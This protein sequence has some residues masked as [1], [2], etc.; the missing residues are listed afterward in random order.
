MSQN[1]GYANQNDI[2]GEP[3]VARPTKNV[4]PL[5]G[6]VPNSQVPN[7][8]DSEQQI[9]R[10]KKFLK[11]AQ[12][13]VI[14]A[15][16]LMSVVSYN[17][18]DSINN[19]QGISGQD[20]SEVLVRTEGRQ[21]DEICQE[22]GSDILI[23]N[24][25]N[26]NG[27]LDEDEVTS[28]TR[29]CHGKEGL[30]GPQGA[31]GQSG[32]TGLMSLLNTE[33]IPFGNANCP[34]GGLR[35]AT[36][37]DSD[38]N[39]T[40]EDH[41][42]VSIDYVCNGQIGNNGISGVSG[43]SALVEQHQPPALLCSNG[44][45]IE[46]GVDDG[47]GLGTADDGILHDDEIVE[48]LRICAEPL[49]YGPITDSFAGVS[50]GYNNACSEFAYLPNSQ[51]I[52]TSGADGIH[53]CELWVSG[54]TL[55]TSELLL[56]IN[57]GNQDSVPGQYL[58]FN[59]MSNHNGELVAFDA[60][61]GI[62]GRELWIT[63]IQENTTTQLTGY[64]GDGIN[65]DASSILW[66]GGM[67]F[68]DS[69]YKFMWTDG[70]NVSSLFDAPFITPEN[71]LLLSS[72]ANSIAAHAQTT[73]VLDEEGMW[74]SA[75]K[76]GIGVEMHRLSNSGIL[77]SWD[78]NQFEDSMPHSIL[79]LDDF[80]VLVADDGLNGKQIHRVN[81]SGT[82]QILTSLTVSSTGLPVSNLANGIG[83]N[84]I[85]DSL[86][87]DAQTS[88]V[89]STV[90]SYNLTS[91]QS[92]ELSQIVLAPGERSGA[93]RIGD[94]LWFDCV[95][96]TTAGELCFSDGTPEGTKLVYEFQP[97][98]ASS[99]IRS[100]ESVDNH[101]LL[102]L[103]GENGGVDSGHCLWSFDTVNMVAKIAYDPW[104]GIGNNSQSG[105]YGDL[106]ISEDV[107]LFIANDGTSGHE[108]HFWSPQ[109]LGD[110]WLIW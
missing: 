68:T 107:A 5:S 46:F 51:M 11:Y 81:V 72:V 86:I 80:A 47:S 6:R 91:G 34:Y 62:N 29:I 97:G 95:T 2:T 20:A 79:P 53:G 41:E 75:V 55:S 50:D 83:I 85:G 24:D 36:G 106:L 52:I 56:D 28:L 9:S 89:D 23:G 67:V 48:S 26:A 90:W 59:V 99:N 58:G 44:I 12:A 70:V 104:Q 66:M 94:V 108:L 96:G 73:M 15:A 74:F 8:S 65:S 22:G 54:G 4:P 110:E 69:N 61:S 19:K 49:N 42:E 30:S 98:I 76:D 92:I 21:A 38:Q 14:I 35:I 57:Q 10:R 31:P 105:T 13:M 1:N 101:L 103:D 87:F 32:E 102:I 71:Q 43:H 39:N 78:L 109:S 18:A 84:L 7:E 88:G 60:D 93:Q 77:T 33:I 100:L 40:L 27:I 45:I 3:V 63:N 16:L 82:H 37:T 17:L 25:I 64:S